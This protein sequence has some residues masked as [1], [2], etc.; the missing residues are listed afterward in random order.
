MPWSAWAGY[1]HDSSRAVGKVDAAYKD[2]VVKFKITFPASLKTDPIG[3]TWSELL[4]EEPW[5]DGTS[6]LVELRPSTS[7]GAGSSNAGAP[8]PKAKPKAAKKKAGDGGG[9]GTDD[10][11]D[12]EAAEDFKDEALWQEYEGDPPTVD[13]FP[14]FKRRS[15]GDT[16]HIPPC[17]TE[18]DYFHLMFPPAAAVLLAENTNAYARQNG[19]GGLAKTGGDTDV[20][21]IYMLLAAVF[22]MTV[23]KIAD[24][25]LY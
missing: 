12:D 15:A 8:A 18:L 10:D 21:E 19:G 23:V 4:G 1:E 16:V 14:A 2:T 3:L 22:Y 24:I 9:S 6:E 11:S 13:G 5:G 17:E 20:G 7:A 25:S